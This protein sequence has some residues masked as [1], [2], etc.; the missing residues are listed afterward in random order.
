MSISA[1][2]K[3]LLRTVTAVSFCCVELLV[4]QKP[5]QAIEILPSDARG[6]RLFPGG[7]PLLL[8]FL[9]VKN[10]TEDRTVLEYDVGQLALDEIS[11]VQLIIEAGN[12]DSGGTPGF[13]DVFTF[14]GDG[15]VN[16]NDFF[17]G[18]FFTTFES[19][20]LLDIVSIDVTE[21]AINSL[22]IGNPFLGFR[23]STTTPDRYSICEGSLFEGFLSNCLLEQQDP[24]TELGPPRLSVAPSASV[25]EPTSPVN[26]LA[27]ILFNIGWLHQRQKKS[28]N[29]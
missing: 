11:S 12:I 4:I 2:W 22:A 3:K 1:K 16:P 23:L 17:A 26:L 29:V 25:S 18:S 7:E 19:S 15:I 21:L 24:K 10:P 20:N 14:S 13:I 9:D 5:I 6:I 27:F 8:D 28:S